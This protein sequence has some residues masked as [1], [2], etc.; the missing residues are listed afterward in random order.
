MSADLPPELKAELEEAV[1]G[2]L[3][4][5]LEAFRNEIIDQC[6]AAALRAEMLGDDP[7]QTILKLKGK[8][9]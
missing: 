3:Q 1:S 5:M 7:Q 2:I 9:Q 4:T 8:P 6:A